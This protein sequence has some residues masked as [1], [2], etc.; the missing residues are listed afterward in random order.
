MAE[1][2]GKPSIMGVARLKAWRVTQRLAF[3]ALFSV[4]AAANPP[5]V[6]CVDTYNRYL[7]GLSFFI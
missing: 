3:M 4:I 1:Q 5:F 7:I 2:G 6:C